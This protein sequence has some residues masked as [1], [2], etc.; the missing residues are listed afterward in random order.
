MGDHLVTEIVGK[1][2]AGRPTK[3]CQEI[4]AKLETA[5]ALGAT[6][7]GACFCAGISR[8]TY[9][10]WAESDP[11]FSDRMEALKQTTVLKA[12]ETVTSNLD[13][14]KI[15]TWLLEKKHPE[16]KPKQAI[17]AEINS[18]ISIAGDILY[19]KKKTTSD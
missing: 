10:A 12:L 18:G 6:V 17:E 13:D 2:K 7:A 19:R 4:E 1:K 3:R 8:Q 9:Y 14:P 15:A 5:F 11:E 16:F